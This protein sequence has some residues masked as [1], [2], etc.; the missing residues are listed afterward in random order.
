MVQNS[1]LYWAKICFLLTYS[2]RTLVL[3]FPAWTKSSLLRD[4]YTAVSIYPFLT[5]PQL[6]NFTIPFLCQYSFKFFKFNF[7][8]ILEYS[9]FTMC[10]KIIQMNVFIKQTHRLQKKKFMGTSL[11]VQWLRIHLPVQGTRVWALVREDP[12]FRGA[13]KPVCHSYWACTLEPTSH[14]YWAHVP[15]LLKLRRLE[16]MQHNKRNHC[17]E[18]PAR[19]NKE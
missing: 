11:V 18:K 12:T 16:P 2:Y 7:Y 5:N 4:S 14:N 3:F 1:P 19:C 10:K 17:N 8:F 13:T 15:Q 9:W 6:K